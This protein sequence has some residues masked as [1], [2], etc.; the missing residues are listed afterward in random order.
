M[1]FRTLPAVLLTALAVTLSAQE[2]ADRATVLLRDGSKV[3]GRIEALGSGT[4]FLRVSLADQ[5]RLPVSN[6][7]L[8]DRKGGASGLPETELREARGPDHLLLLVGGRSE[9][10]QLLSIKGGEG[11]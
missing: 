6:V 5:R 10:G 11:S 3:E 7:A 1:L 8:I 2:G 4:L 9:K